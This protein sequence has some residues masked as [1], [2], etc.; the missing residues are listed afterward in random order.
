MKLK[1][2]KQTITKTFDAQVYEIPLPLLLEE[3]S[4]AICYD[5]NPDDDNA[6]YI[7]LT[8]ANQEYCDT[9]VKVTLDGVELDMTKLVFH[10]AEGRAT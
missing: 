7:D 9:L 2:S 8:A 1:S 6:P 5:T 3:G 10:I 4:V